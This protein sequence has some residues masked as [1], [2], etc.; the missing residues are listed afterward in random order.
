M[1][2]ERDRERDGETRRETKGTR[3][4]KDSTRI[5]EFLINKWRNYKTL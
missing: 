4:R 2:A 5:V 1:E 3:A